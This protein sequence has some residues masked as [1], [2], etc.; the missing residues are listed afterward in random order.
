MFS[1]F[2]SFARFFF[3]RFL[4]SG[5]QLRRGYLVSLK[6]QEVETARL[7]AL[8]RRHLRD[9]SLQLAVPVVALR[10]LFRK[11][12]ERREAVKVI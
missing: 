9:L 11:R 2:W 12:A 8:V 5:L 3:E 4:F 10:I 1:L 6:F 7:L